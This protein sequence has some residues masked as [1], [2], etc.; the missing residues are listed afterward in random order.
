M[1]PG[2]VEVETLAAAND[3]LRQELLL[4][5]LQQTTAPGVWRRSVA[6]GS[7]RNSL[8]LDQV[9]EETDGVHTATATVARVDM[10][11]QASQHIQE[12]RALWA[13]L[14]RD[15]ELEE[16]VRTRYPHFY[17]LVAGP[18]AEAASMSRELLQVPVNVIQRAP[19]EPVLDQAAVD[20]AAARAREEALAQ[21]AE[22][23]AELARQQAL[24]EQQARELAERVQ[25]LEQELSGMHTA[26]AESQEARERELLEVRESLKARLEQARLA[27]VNRTKVFFFF[28]GGGGGKKKFFFFFFLLKI[29]PFKT[30]F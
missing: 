27:D 22:R 15:P 19:T 4:R 30:K 11:L 12:G 13:E 9:P 29:L 21:A 14:E 2:S 26:L 17:Q 23:E 8:L 6:G 18:E 28:F 7:L 3:A 10:E 1:S 5:E 20:A 16:T 24:K 25:Q